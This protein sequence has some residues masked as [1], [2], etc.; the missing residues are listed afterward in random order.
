MTR[1]FD[2][3]N[4]VGVQHAGL[5]FGAERL[6][7]RFLDLVDELNE[8]Y[9]QFWKKGLSRPF[10]GF[11]KLATPKQS[12]AQFDE[13][14]GTIWQIYEIVKH[15]LNKRRALAGQ[16]DEDE[17]RFE[18]DDLG[19]VVTD[20]IQQAADALKLRPA[21][22]DKLKNLLNTRFGFTLPWEEAGL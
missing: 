17:Y 9:Y 2:Y 15:L 12:K 22:L 6:D 8:A 7:E 1:T 16:V 11:D 4:K 21:L 19:V 13:L 5:R 10:L 18:R 14:H 3:V 20:R